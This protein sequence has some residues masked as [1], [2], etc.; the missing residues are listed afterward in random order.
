MAFTTWAELKQQLLND[1]A[2]GAWRTISSYTL[3]G[4]RAVSYR[5]LDE[6]KKLLT[7]VEEEAAKEEGTPRYWGRT[8]ARQGGRG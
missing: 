1:L 5:S 7:M 8:Y 6:F 4:G 2:D 3:P